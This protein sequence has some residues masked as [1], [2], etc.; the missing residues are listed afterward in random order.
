MARHTQSGNGRN[1]SKQQR[2][3]GDQRGRR[4]SDSSGER[5]GSYGGSTRHER[6][7][8]VSYRGPEA[9]PYSRGGRVDPDDDRA[10]GTHEA[11]EDRDNYNATADHLHDPGP[12]SFQG[13]GFFEEGAPYDRGGAHVGMGHAVGYGPGP[14]P[15]P[16][17]GF[18]GRGPKGYQRS[19]ERLL[20]EIN[21]RLTHDDDIDAHEISVSV[22][23]GEVTLTGTVGSRAQ[24]RRAD[25]IAEDV[26]GVQ[27]VQNNLRVQKQDR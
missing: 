24:K 7:Q 23:K 26:S 22:E 6:N 9:P 15:S 27:H 16:G 5:S 25:D 14:N 19:D 13:T 3:P 4:A 20:E 2:Q 11:G 10:F 17:L 1:Q 18:R 8:G 12:Q 21:E